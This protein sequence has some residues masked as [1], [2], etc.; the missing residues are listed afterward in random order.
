MPGG[1]EV[2]HAFQ[3][4]LQDLVRQRGE[5]ISKFCYFPSLNFRCPFEHILY[6]NFFIL[7]IFSLCVFILMI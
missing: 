5:V 3:D 6:V 7:K 1:K 2:E 4:V